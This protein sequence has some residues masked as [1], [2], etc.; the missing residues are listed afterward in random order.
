MFVQVIYTKKKHD[1]VQASRLKEYIATG[2]IAM[3]RRRDKWVRVGVD[4]MRST[5]DALNYQGTDRR[6]AR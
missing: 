6:M 4:P 3:F 5:R 1:L 2:R